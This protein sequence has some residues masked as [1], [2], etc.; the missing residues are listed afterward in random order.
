MSGNSSKES[1]CIMDDSDYEHDASTRKRSSRGSKRKHWLREE[2]EAIVSLVQEFG[3]KDWTLISK[4][5][6]QRYAIKKRSA[7]QCRERWHNHLDPNIK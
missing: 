2:D 5:T 6:K 7:K 4:M 1:E 3:T